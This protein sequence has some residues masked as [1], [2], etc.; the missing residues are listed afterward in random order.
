VTPSPATLTSIGAKQQ[1]G[2]AVVDGNGN[3]ITVPL[4]WRSSN[5]AVATVNATGEATSTGNGTTEISAVAGAGTP[6]SVVGRASLQVTQAIRSITVSPPSAA[7][8]AIGETVQFTATA[9]DGNNNPVAGVR[10]TW[11]STNTNSATVDST[12]LARA[13]AEGA[14][15][16]FAD[17]AGVRGSAILNIG[18]R[19]T[20]VAVTPPTGTL[21][22]LGA[23]LQ[24]SATSFDAT[25]HAVIGH[26]VTWTSS[27]PGVA[28]VD[29][30][31]KV[32]AVDNGSV[33]IRAG[34]DDTAGYAIVTVDQVLTSILISPAHDT[35]AVGDTARYSAIGRD[36]NNQIVGDA[37]FTWSVADTAIATINTNGRL[38]A[39]APGS[40]TVSA[41]S[42]AVVATVPLLVRTSQPATIAYVSGNNQSAQVGTPVTNP[43]VVKVTDAQ[44]NPFQGA[45]VH[46]VVT[47]G[48]GIASPDSSITNAQGLA[49]ASW[50]M[51]TSTAGTP[52]LEARAT[53]L[54]GSPVVFNAIADPGAT[55]SVVIAGPDSVALTSLGDT[56]RFFAAAQ[57]QYGNHTGAAITWLSL[58]TVVARVNATGTV[59]AFANGRARIVAS[60]NPADTVIVNVTQQVASITAT[61]DPVTINA[62]GD[63]LQ[64]SANVR[65]ARNNVVA[66]AVTWISIHPTMRPWMHRA[67]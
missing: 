47:F 53:N 66:T 57:D 51:G 35:I 43:L 50:I 20:R 2:A 24:L 3:P 5:A 61:P 14:T 7:V 4:V 13:V 40:T 65:D 59:T 23:T 39:R 45:V 62:I 27:N 22:A 49:S 10:F 17:A 16:I 44:N 30:T 21:N 67:A 54:T 42:G 8:E 25:N 48:G 37:L 46:W 38:I 11:S 26:P 32:T 33:T 63:T 9:R 28:S 34:V 15:S 12:G 29:G 58:D 56:I 6:D 60:V 19:V 55:A 1:F 18:Q 31:G 41:A 52:T 64:L 36:A